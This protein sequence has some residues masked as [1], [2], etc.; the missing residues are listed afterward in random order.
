MVM[1]PFLDCCRRWLCGLLVGRKAGQGQ[2]AAEPRTRDCPVSLDGLGRD[3]EDGC[4]FFDREPAEVAELHDLR[5]ARRELGQPYERFVECRPLVGVSRVEN[6]TAV[7]ERHALLTFAAALLAV[8][9]PRIVDEDLAHQVRGDANKL[10][11]VFPRQP[12]LGREPQVHLM[13]KGRR[14]ERM[15][16]SLLAKVGV[17]NSAQFSV[18]RRRKRVARSRGRNS[19]GEATLSAICRKYDTSSA[20]GI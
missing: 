2:L 14:L 5:L 20:V 7:G 8:A 12:M 9:G 16:W 3:L 11:A 15:A 18:E 4:G 13:D 1:T 17:G 19:E 6:G 10:P